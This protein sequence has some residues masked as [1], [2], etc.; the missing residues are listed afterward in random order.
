[1][2]SV[3]KDEIPSDVLRQVADELGHYVYALVDPRNGIP[4]YIGKGTGERFAAHGREALW[5][6]DGGDLETEVDEQAF[7]DKV[8]KI[9]E[10]DG[11]IDIWIIRHGLN[12][13]EYTQVE[14]ACI[15]L[16]TSFPVVPLEELEEGESRIPDAARLQ[17]TNRRKEA[18]RGHGIVRLERLI[19]EKAAPVLEYD[20]PLL[21][22]SLGDWVDDESDIPGG[23]TRQ[24][25]GYK[26]EWLESSVRK[27]HYRE[28]GESTCSWW[29][30]SED[31]IQ[32]KGIEYVVAAY[33]GVT[34]ALFRIKPDTWEEAFEPDADD[35]HGR[36]LGW[37]FEIVDSGDIFDQVVG[38]YGHRV[39]P[40]PQQNQR[41]W[42]W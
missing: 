23:G 32:Q 9:R 29:K 30:L 6:Y 24:G 36:R 18:S 28:I 42:P 31:T 12:K 39:E 20:E 11:D 10:L 21:I 41:Y 25:F 27:Q 34:R 40:K 16:L 7:S 22:I 38:E 8:R 33:R 4:F 26:R 19:E 35:G 3:T 14:A 17:L 1:M 5:T 15:D 37:E 2:M 13:A